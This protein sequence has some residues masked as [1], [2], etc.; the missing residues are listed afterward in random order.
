MVSFPPPLDQLVGH[1]R[2]ITR[3]AALGTGAATLAIIPV[4]RCWS[5][6]DLASSTPIARFFSVAALLDDRRF[7]HDAATP[8]ARLQAAGFDYEVA[9][10]GASD[11]QIV[12]AGGLKLYVRSTPIRPEQFG[13]I[14]D[15]GDDL[16][17]LQRVFDFAARR[18]PLHL[19]RVHRIRPVKGREALLVRS[20]TR[21][22]FEPGARIEN[23]P[24]DCSRYE[25]LK[26][27]DVCDVEI[28]NAM[29][30]G[31]RDLN[32]AIDG[33]WGNGIQ[34][35]GAADNIR[36]RN[37][38]TNNM[39]GD[40]IF[41]GQDLEH[42]KS[43]GSVEIWSPK[44]DNCRRQGMSITGAQRCI[45]HS[46][47]WTRTNGR[48]PQAGLDIE[49]DTE[50]AVLGE[51]RIIDPVTI[52]NAGSGIVVFLGPLRR[53]TSPVSIE[54]IGHQS[55]D[56]GA[57][58]QFMRPGWA[59]N[60]VSGSV[61]YLNPQVTKARTAGIIVEDWDARGPNILVQRPT[62]TDPGAALGTSDR[63][64]AGIL[65]YNYLNNEATT[66]GNVTIIN[67]SIV[68]T[69]T[70]TKLDRY[71]YVQN[72]KTPD[73]VEKVRIIDPVKLTGARYSR[74]DGQV[75][76]S[77][78]NAVASVDHANT[79][80]PFPIVNWA[81]TGRY[82]NRGAPGIVTFALSERETPVGWPSVTVVARDHPI[83]LDPGKHNTIVPGGRRGQMA[84]IPAGSQARLQRRSPTEWQ[85]ESTRSPVFRL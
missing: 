42:L 68:F 78:R 37:P 29:L 31:R 54:I 27:H 63:D 1:G 77:D 76:W 34:I 82:T 74:I 32:K 53:S 5:S 13:V 65:I 47:R 83:R 50:T 61:R 80:V 39:W 25:M 57:G 33:E 19:S 45:V 55:N 52:G 40:G 4:A 43:P 6:A 62:I 59:G 17:G 71:F 8:G 24:H 26:L 60:Y 22:V 75:E 7:T 67:P 28:V 23:L 36:L 9:P 30:D 44:A 11:H 20:H 81:F 56:D 70:T 69:R 16:D 58:A 3:R 35:L 66:L 51:I 64:R 49:P 73:A 72:Y 15:G 38:V 2:L 79:V 41:I 21:I 85:I 84:E 18:S 46:P 14:G 10:T 48:L 12:T